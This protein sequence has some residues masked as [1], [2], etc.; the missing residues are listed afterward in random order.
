[1]NAYFFD[2]YE[3]AS[4]A[5]WQLNNFLLG[6]GT[7]VDDMRAPRARPIDIHERSSQFRFYKVYYE[8]WSPIV[9]KMMGIYVQTILK[10]LSTQIVIP[11]DAKNYIK[12][13]DDQDEEIPEE[14]QAQLGD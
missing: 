9:L 8:H 13:E 4:K 2:Q 5:L 12:L 7:G 6:Y 14:I 3:K 10:G 1:M 11:R